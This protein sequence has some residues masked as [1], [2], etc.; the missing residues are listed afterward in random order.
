[1]QK[2]IIDQCNWAGRPVIT[3]TQMLESMIENPRPTRAEATDVANAVLD[4]T[5][6]LMLS[7]ETAAGK[8]PIEAVKTMARIAERTEP[9]FDNAGLERRFQE[10]VRKEGIDHT[11]AIAHA[12]AQL[13]WR[14]KPAAIVTTTTSGQTPKLVSKFRPKT[15]ILCATWKERVQRRMAVVWGV[16]TVMVEHP[17]STDEA[18]QAAIDALMR[19]KRLACG[20]QVIVTAGVP[21]G[22]PGNTNMILLQEVR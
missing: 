15:A 19:K 9:Y 17:N 20:N 21:A 3:A 7:G 14:I 1:M 5:D 8:F 22:Q 13:A 4:G 11:D 6:A 2:R 16:E 10:K 18:I 12:V